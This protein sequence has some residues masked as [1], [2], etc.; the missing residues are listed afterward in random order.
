MFSSMPANEGGGG[1][2]GGGT[3][4]EPWR[5]EPEA[6][7]VDAWLVRGSSTRVLSPM[8]SSTVLARE[9]SP[10]Y[11]GEAR[12]ESMDEAR[13]D[14]P[15][16][17]VEAR[18]DAM[19]A[20]L[21]TAEA[22]REAAV[23]TEVTPAYTDDRRVLLAKREMSNSAEWPVAPALRR[24]WMSGSCNLPTSDIARSFFATL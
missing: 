15:D 13:R 21:E 6:S 3:L 23:N 17:A 12:G 2:S 4:H 14:A 11:R 5:G 8:D 7:N 18:R 24:W 10:E 22:R 1:K 16:T 9:S 20:C 19:E